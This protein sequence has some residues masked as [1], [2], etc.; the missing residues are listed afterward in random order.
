MTRN[1][2]ASYR[3]VNL[4]PVST[5]LEARRDG[6]MLVRSTA[7]LLPYPER[8]TERLAHWA[9]RTPRQTFLA[10]RGPDGAWKHLTYG[11]AWRHVHALGQAL[12]DRGL[13]PQRPLVVLSEPSVA[14]ALI[15]LAAMH[16]G[17]PYVPVSPPYSL[18]STDFARL[19]DVMAQIRPGLVYAESGSRF[20]RA[21]SEVAIPSGAD[22]VLG[23][24][25]F[26]GPF[27]SLTDL[28]VTPVTPAVAAAHARITPDTVA[29]VLFTSG[30]TGQPKGVINTHRMLGA[31]ATQIVQVFPF[32]DAE[33]PVLVDWLPWHHTYGGNKVLGLTLYCGGTLY[34]DGGRATPQGIHET[35]R[36]L[37]EISPTVYFSIPRGYTELLPHLEADAELRRRFFER[38]RL[39]FYAAASLS[40]ATWD[41]IEALSVRATGERVVIA[42]GL[43]C[44]E[45]APSSLMTHWSG[46]RAGLLG[47]PVP[48]LEVKLV[49]SGDK[50]EARYRGPNVMPGYWGDAGATHAAFDDEGYYCTG[51]ALRLA[52]PHH[53][54]AGMIFDG[55]IAEDFKLNT[56]T[57]VSVGTLRA[58]LVQAGAPLIHDVVITGHDAP[59]LG[60]LVF[61]N[62]VATR[63]ALELPLDTPESALTTHPGV[64]AALRDVLEAS[65]AQATGSSTL[66]RRLLVADFTP[67]LD[68]GE[69]T[70]KGSL[71]QRGV[72]ARHPELVTELHAAVPSARTL[73]L[74]EDT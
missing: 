32:L 57:W 50:L 33:P 46:G 34:L 67:S 65:A 44:T 28:L 3:P 12:L 13:S 43:G 69:I 29:K 55:R 61:L 52:D 35:V 56:G 38:L 18:V 9:A 4:A 68:A 19:R 30:S 66:V 7:P 72:L 45:S 15:G 39:V 2:A 8:A 74:E 22:V 64:R 17:I 5:V 37:L 60:A 42:T 49:P 58:S 51:D 53:A 48:G 11:D 10:Q 63:R 71:N 16:I 59:W 73:T 24:G 36:N 31:N 54:D 21:L 47:V 26:D 6:T 40:Q 70:D 62:P 27:T 41:A 1:V 25:V 23:D 20:A 14:H